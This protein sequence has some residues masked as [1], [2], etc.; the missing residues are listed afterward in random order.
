MLSQKRIYFSLIIFKESLTLEQLSA[1]V[2]CGSQSVVVA[3]WIRPTIEHARDVP[4]VGETRSGLYF[5]VFLCR[6]SLL[7]QPF[8]TISLHVFLFCFGC[9]FFF[10]SRIICFG[11]VF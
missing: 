1:K 11:S 5:M 7:A 10:K 8:I 9:V 4:L 3:R 2:E 6:V